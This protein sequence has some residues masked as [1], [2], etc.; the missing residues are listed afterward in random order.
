MINT[1]LIALAIAILATIGLIVTA[2]AVSLLTGGVHFFFGRP[3]LR[4]L[5]SEH[6]DTGVAFSLRWNNSKEPANFDVV[7]IKLFNP[8]GT[9]TQI[10]VSHKLNGYDY[11]FAEDIDFGERIKPLFD[12][13]GFDRA[14]IMIELISSK[15]GFS[16]QA[17]MRTIDFMAKRAS[18]EMTA[19]EFNDKY[20][21]KPET[22]YFEIP[23]RSF[24][25]GPLPTTNKSLKIATNPAF[26]GEFAGQAATASADAPPAENFNVSKVW[27]EPGC[28]VCNECE[29]IY[30]EVFEVKADTCI[31]R[32]GF[33]TDDGL[34][35]LE[36]AEACPVEVIKFEKAN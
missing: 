36:A 20:G 16:H 25:S 33:P 21:A 35:V 17:E 32:P 9:P 6:G 19:Q 34:K 4:L 8:F 2:A 28:I 24:V 1:T 18:A 11:D 27:I 23:K 31:I 3:R 12:A 29:N 15:D 22:Q 13:K 10:E 7:K 14:R 30:P 26:A 5:K